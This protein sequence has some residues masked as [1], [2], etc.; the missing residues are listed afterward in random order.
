MSTPVQ[1]H[2]DGGKIAQLQ[3]FLV[4][5]LS[6]APSTPAQSQIYFDTTLGA[7]G[8]C[9]N[10]TGPVW[11]YVPITAAVLAT[12]FD[13]QSTLVAV[14][15]NTPIVAVV[16]TE[17]TV[18]RTAGVNSGNIGALT[19]AQV[20]T[21]L[22][23]LNLFTAPAAP[24]SMG[25]QEVTN[26]A[27]PTA[28]T[29]AATKGYVDAFIQGM[30]WKDSVRAATTANITLSAPQTI[31]GVSV[32]AGERVLV[33]NQTTGSQ[34]GIYLVA[35]GAWTRTTDADTSAK[36][37]SGQTVPVTEGTANGD[38]AFVL[39]TNDP[40]TLATTSLTYTQLPGAGGSGTV[41]K[42]AGTIG[43]G[44]TTAIAVTHSLG[45]QDVGIHVYDVASGIEVWC[46]KAR[47]S[48][49]VC[50]LTFAVAPA[51]NSLRVVVFA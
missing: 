49:T 10:A 14:S 24:I 33:K 39:T 40:I 21:A 4:Q 19:W 6:S 35:A 30:D 16:G 42:F 46:D 5:P 12:L 3:N 41:T 25:S 31:D 36:V 27:T 1:N 15:D 45:S 47:T 2:L 18:G 34:N 22:G 51:T 11:Q 9:T 38:K 8:I 13:A 29:S 44:S 48:T 26:V 7:L 32:I 37:T 50:T 23:A 43:D 28:G 17:G 20:R